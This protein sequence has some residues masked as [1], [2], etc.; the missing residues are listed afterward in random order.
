ME[1]S[2]AQA[3]PSTNSDALT[4]EV[5]AVNL[6]ASELLPLDALKEL[7]DLLEFTLLLQELLLSVDAQLLVP[8]A[9][10]KLTSLGKPALLPLVTQ[11]TTAV[12]P[13]MASEET[14]E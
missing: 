12:E 5:H 8:L 3:S 11:S 7:L 1:V 9:M 2:L 10:D 14:G 13:A 6:T 4:V